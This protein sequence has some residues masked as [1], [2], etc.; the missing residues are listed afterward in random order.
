MARLTEADWQRVRQLWE[1]DGRMGYQW[2]VRSLAAE[3]LHLPPTTLAKRVKIHG[4]TKTVPVRGPVLRQDKDKSLPTALRY[5]KTGRPTLY[6]PGF[7]ELTFKLCLLGATMAQIADIFKINSQTLY[8]WQ[9][10]YPDFAAALDSGRLCADAE[11]AAALYHRA[12]GYS[13]KDTKVALS[14]GA[15]VSIEV[16]KHYPPDTMAAKIW[17]HNRQPDL[18]KEK[19]TVE[20]NHQLDAELLAAIKTDF[21]A[22]MEK[23]RLRQLAVL[24]ERRLLGQGEL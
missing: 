14:E 10:K 19:H 24:D 21:V 6:E 15:F 13:H 22:R 20:H 4:W 18:W 16:D 7:A 1:G 2:L 23:A 9:Q 11:I 17:L 5:D 8:S 3:G 12:K